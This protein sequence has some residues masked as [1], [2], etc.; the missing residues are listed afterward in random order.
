MFGESPDGLMAFMV[1]VVVVVVDLVVGQ[2]MTIA[3]PLT[4]FVERWFLL[5]SSTIE[6]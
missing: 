3:F 4:C 1:L 2:S 6:A 5:Q